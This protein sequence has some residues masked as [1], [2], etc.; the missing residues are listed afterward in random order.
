MAQDAQAWIRNASAETL[1][2]SG[3]RKVL[4]RLGRQVENVAQMPDEE[5]SG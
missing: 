5:E 4:G 3:A 1:S 2:V